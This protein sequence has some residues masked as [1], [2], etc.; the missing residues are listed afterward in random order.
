MDK[1]LQ[2]YYES[3]FDLLASKGWEDLIEDIQGMITN[4]NSVTNANS[5]EELFMNKGRID[6]LNWLSNLK[7]VS[8]DA[9]EEL[10]S[11][12]SV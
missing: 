6:I 10:T 12:D 7:K 4:Y 8:D 11:E 9:Y 1:E 3:R 5:V 2:D